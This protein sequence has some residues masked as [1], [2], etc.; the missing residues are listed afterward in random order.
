M[1]I[2]LKT[3]KKKQP[4]AIRGD[5][6]CQGNQ[7]AERRQ[8]RHNAQEPAALQG[9]E[10]RRGE[11]PGAESAEQEGHPRRGHREVFFCC[12]VGK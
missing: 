12:F 4:L 5:V 2:Y 8:Q 1:K 3:L 9:D 11:K 7:G 6:R 10:F